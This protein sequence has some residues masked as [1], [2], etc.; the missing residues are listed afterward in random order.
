MKIESNENL[1]SENIEQS[2]NNL[3]NQASDLLGNRATTGPTSADRAEA[4]KALTNNGT[5]PDLQLDMGP[6]TGSNAANSGSFSPLGDSSNLSGP[7]GDSS[8][9][10]GS[11]N[12]ISNAINDQTN[13]V[14][15]VTTAR[16]GDARP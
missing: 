13:A 1:R 8:S 9:T 11:P 15:N 3:R 10:T 6:N 14:S 2:E 12:S 16:P 4:S 5:L 7:S